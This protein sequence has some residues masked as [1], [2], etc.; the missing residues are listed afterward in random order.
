MLIIHRM[1]TKLGGGCHPYNYH[2][3][4]DNCHPEDAANLSDSPH[5]LNIPCLWT[6]NIL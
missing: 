2:N 5:S 3:L 4:Q 6:V 1:V